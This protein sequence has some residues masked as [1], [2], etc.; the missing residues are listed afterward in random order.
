MYHLCFCEA[1]NLLETGY[2]SILNQSVQTAM[3]SCHRVVVDQSTFTLVD[4]QIFRR[5]AGRE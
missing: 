4:I 1:L 2:L 3:S 5:H